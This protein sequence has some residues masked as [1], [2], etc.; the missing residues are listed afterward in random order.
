MAQVY[1][2]T[3]AIDLAIEEAEIVLQ[4]LPTNES[5][6][7][8]M[9]ATTRKGDLTKALSY[10]EKVKKVNPSNAA[11]Y[12][13]IGNIKLAQK[14]RA[15]AMQNFEEALRLEPARLDALAML[16]RLQ[17]AGEYSGNR[18]TNRKAD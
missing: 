14:Q 11:A 17:L 2:T 18:G 9:G 10:F 4:T 3:G 1:F 15:E 12:V 5:M 7:L 16:A 6:L 8:V 13:N